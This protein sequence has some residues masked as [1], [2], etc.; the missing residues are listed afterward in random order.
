MSSYPYLLQYIVGYSIQR[1]I[2]YPP[3]ISFLKE[4]QQNT[5]FVFKQFEVSSSF[6]STLGGDEGR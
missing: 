3:P 2:R 4:Q 6:I 5:A 1:Q